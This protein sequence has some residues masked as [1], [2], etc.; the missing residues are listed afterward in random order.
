MF[1][2]YMGGFHMENRRVSPLRES[3]SGISIAFLVGVILGQ[4]VPQLLRYVPLIYRLGLEGIVLAG[5]VVEN[6]DAR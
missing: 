6:S 2:V 1:P 5:G 4:H 3:D